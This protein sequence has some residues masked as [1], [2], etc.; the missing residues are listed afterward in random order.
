MRMSKRNIAILSV[1]IVLVTLASIL[2]IYYF[3]ASYPK[4]SRTM[5][6]EVDI[7]GLSE[8]F[9]PQ[10]MA[11]V[12]SQDAYLI[13]GYMKDTS[14]PSRIYYVDAITNE[15]HYVTISGASREE[16]EY[17]HLGGVASSGDIVFVSSE[18]TVMRFSIDNIKN[19]DNNTSVDVEGEFNPYNRASF[20]YA[21]GNKLYVGEFYRKGN[22]ETDASHVVNTADG[23]NRA[24]VN[25]YTID[26]SSPS[27]VVSTTPNLVISL[28]N[29]VQGF[30]KTIDGKIVLSTSYSIF[31]SKILV[32]KDNTNNK[33]DRKIE[34]N[35]SSVPLYI[36]DSTNYIDT[37]KAPS[38]SEG[39]D[40][41]DGRVHI[42]FESACSKYAMVNRTRTK[43][44][45]SIKV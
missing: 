5:E 14:K 3:G 19:A 16:L 20:C 24:I 10:G 4:F 9:V 25:E 30:C 11:Y 18:E 13:S 43:S 35:G 17:G 26:E 23:E 44:V 40:Y 29:Q 2:L 22:Y 39:L 7:P 36:L 33:T 31:D 45:L 42:L 34:I 41:V 1:I 32:Y 12:D 38:M 15:N 27:G 8:G 21:D 6:K 28:P 37:I